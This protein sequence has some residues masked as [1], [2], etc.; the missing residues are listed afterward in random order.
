MAKTVNDIPDINQIEFQ[1]KIDTLTGNETNL[2]LYFI[3]SISLFQFYCLFM[4]RLNFSGNFDF[5]YIDV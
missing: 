2:L 5:E 3:L 1:I 4:T